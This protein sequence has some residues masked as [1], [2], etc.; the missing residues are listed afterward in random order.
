MGGAAS[1]AAASSNENITGLILWAT[2]NDLRRTFWN[3]LG[4]TLYNRLDAGETLHLEDER[5]KIDLTPDFLTDLDKYDLSTI[6]SGWQERTILI[7]HGEQ[8]VTVDVAQGR[9]NFALAGGRKELYT[10][11]NGDHTFS[12]CAEE[13]NKIICSWLQKTI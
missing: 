10:F 2:P 6:I 4:E 3:A 8:D 1:L 13:A 5:G 9:R 12:E 7:L 11:A